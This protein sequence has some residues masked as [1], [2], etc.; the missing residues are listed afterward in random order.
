MAIYLS[1]QRMRFSS[2]DGYEKFKTV[3]AD[4]RN[5]LLKL[6]GFMHLTWWVH[7]DDLF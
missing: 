7:P 5:H 1:M 3:F 2:R 4:V 6:P